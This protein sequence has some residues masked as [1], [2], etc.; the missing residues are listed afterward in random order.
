MPEVKRVTDSSRIVIFDYHCVFDD[1]TN[2]LI[3]M[4]QWYKSD[5]VKRFYM[6]HS[7]QSALQLETISEAVPIPNSIDQIDQI[8]NYIIDDE[9][10][11]S[12]E[13][14]LK[15]EGKIKSYNY[16][17][18]IPS[19]TIVWLVHET[20]GFEE[21]PYINYVLQN[22]EIDSFIMNSK[23]DLSKMSKEEIIAKL[24]KFRNVSLNKTKGLDF[25]KQN[26]LCFFFQKNIVKLGLKNSNL[27]KDLFKWFEF[28]ERSADD[29]NKEEDFVEL[30]KEKHFGT[31]IERL[32]CNSLNPMEREYLI[33]ES[34][35]IKA[36]QVYANSLRFE[37]RVEGKAEGIV[38]GEAK[39]KT[40]GKAEVAY[41][42]CKFK[43]FNPQGV[44][45]L[46]DFI[47]LVAPLGLDIASRVAAYAEEDATSFEDLLKFVYKYTG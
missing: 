37:G 8:R 16:N 41:K 20:L 1:D 19:V 21:T 4:Q 17:E 33:K 26:K 44:M 40:E 35:F 15:I 14:E 45:S 18:V 28:A 42:Y 3:D 31:I 23:E 11:A 22:E 7:V 24:Q 5:L 6:Y 9:E 34:D 2:L 39:G 12:D 38:E 43:G 32:K 25:L 29:N 10:K 47:K 13:K 36:Q 30:A 27:N 46:D